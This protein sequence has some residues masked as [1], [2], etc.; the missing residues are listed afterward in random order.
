M[1]GETPRPNRRRRT[2]TVVA[3]AAAVVLAGAAAAAAVGYGGGVEGTADAAVLPPATEKVT[4]QTLIDAQAESGEL[5]YGEPTT[6]SGKLTG[7]ITAL[8]ATGA[9]VN[10]GGTLYR[11]DN[12]RV[13]LLYGSLPAYRTL[14]PGVEGADVK[15]FEREIAALGYDGFTADDEYTAATAD[16]VREWQEDL[17]LP[18]TGRVEQG[19]V[20]YAPSQVR[21]D[22]HSAA[23][24]DAAQP[25]KGVLTYTRTAR[26]VTVSLG[27]DDQRLAR[28]GAGV[29]VTTPTGARVPGRITATET[30]VESAQDPDAEPETKIEVTVS[31]TDPKALAGFDAASVDVDF[32]ASQRPNVLTVPVAALLALAEGGYGVEIVEGAGSRVVA[33]ETGLFASGRV[34]VS[35][36]GIAEGVT[37]GM[38]A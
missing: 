18:E 34:E 4:R 25:G 5:G 28:K 22:A 8:A 33:V 2:G 37:V 35:G 14:S 7:T 1:S 30:V 36:E 12:E 38:P 11:V 17:G 24:G 13:V 32:T 3:A 10:R 26:V 29:Q 20:V 6:V 9:T 23:V 31:V 19:R 15:Q 16:A 21:I 27:V